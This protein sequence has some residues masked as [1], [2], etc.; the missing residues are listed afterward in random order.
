MTRMLKTIIYFITKTP[1]L[2]FKKHWF[3]PDKTSYKKM[4]HQINKYAR[5]ISLTTLVTICTY[6]LRWVIS[7]SL[8]GNL[9]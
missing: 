1:L 7:V 5:Y 4:F 9:Q 8:L 3:S 2:L 6:F